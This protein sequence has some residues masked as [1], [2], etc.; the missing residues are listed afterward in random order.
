MKKTRKSKYFSLRFAEYVP[1]IHY[2]NESIKILKEQ[3]KILLTEL[4]RRLMKA[5]VKKKLLLT[6]LQKFKKKRT[7]H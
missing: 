3:K 4:L 2:M 7:K 6:K 5:K 1:Y